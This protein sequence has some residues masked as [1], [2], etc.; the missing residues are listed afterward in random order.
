MGFTKDCEEVLI[1]DGSAV[2]L[3]E[4]WGVWVAGKKN[5]YRV[6]GGAVWHDKIA[7]YK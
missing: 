2:F 3:A 1:I 4:G 7:N 5:H 6:W